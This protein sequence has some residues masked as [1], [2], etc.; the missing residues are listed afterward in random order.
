MLLTSRV[1][2]LPIGPYRAT[3]AALSLNQSA[4]AS[5]SVSSVCLHARASV[6][7]RSRVP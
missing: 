5:R 3:A 7:E 2:Q 1:S 4:T 6:A